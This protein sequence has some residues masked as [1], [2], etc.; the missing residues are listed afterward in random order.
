LK[1]MTGYGRAA[2]LAAARRPELQATPPATMSERAAMLSA[3]AA[4]ARQQLRDYGV[5]ERS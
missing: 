3:A 1:E 4:G 2:A 5:L